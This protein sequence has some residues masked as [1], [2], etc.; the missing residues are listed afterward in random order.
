MARKILVTGASGR[1]GSA[2]A[3]AL[4]AEYAVTQLS[5]DQPP[6]PELRDIGPYFAGDITDMDLVTGAM[7]GANVVVHCAAIPGAIEPFDRLMATNVLGTFC[8]L[9]AAGRS[10]SVEQVVFMSSIQ[11]H[12]LHE[13]HGGLQTPLYL[14]VNEAHPSLANGYYDTS[15][16]QGEYLCEVYTKRFGKPCVALRP[17][18]IITRD[19]EA[20]FK[21]VP[22]P[23]RPH[24]NDYVG[25]SDLIAAVQRAIQYRPPGN[26]EAFLISAD[27]QRTTMP[28]VELAKQY[29][30]GVPYDLNAL[31]RCE[32]FGALVDCTRAKERLGWQPHFRCQR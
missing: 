9:E 30:P 10:A 18:W 21:A 13:E 11:W 23:D 19:L 24:L 14:P 16:V 31:E 27:D 32:G 12:G 5:L 29:Y 28:S 7:D 8:V 15:K 25:T 17:G 4:S 26:F 22:P 20:S 6:T 3:L 2:L 1:F